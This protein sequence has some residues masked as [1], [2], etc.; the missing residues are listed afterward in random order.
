[1]KPFVS[2]IIPTYHDWGRLEK[3]LAALLA[4]TYPQDRFEV[5]VV[6]NDPQDPVP[7]M[8]LPNNFHILS[9]SK[10]GSYAARNK[11]ISVAK[12]EVLAFTD[13]DAI[14]YENWLEKAVEK[15]AGGAER[16]AGRVELFFKSD[17]L[18][19]AEIFEKAYAFRQEKNA[20]N[21]VSVTANMIVWRHYFYSVGLFNESM[22]SGGDVEWGLRAMNSGI[23]I[24]YSPDVVVK[25][26]A[27]SSFNELM[28]KRRRVVDGGIKISVSIKPN[29]RLWFVRGFL[30]PLRSLNYLF[31]RKD[32]STKEKFVAFIL[33]YFIKV[34]ST[35][36]KIWKTFS[37][38][39]NGKI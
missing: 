14:P 29:Q 4:Q 38:L 9:E 36:R 24:I 2:V 27:R 16:I 25:H 37:L 33:E 22:L 3:C 18:T 5:L 39:K 11:G 28:K 8:D 20:I 35:L 34:Y 6:N 10:P 30:P 13:S 26:P 19:F 23:S 1:M 17:K 7:E 31:R 15:L 12:G 21:G 32:L